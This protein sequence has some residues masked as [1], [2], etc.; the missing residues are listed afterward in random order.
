[1]FILISRCKLYYSE[2]R[3]PLFF[4]KLREYI[5]HL[6]PLTNQTALF[7]L[8]IRTSPL[9]GVKPIPWRYEFLCPFGVA[10]RNRFRTFYLANQTGLL[11]QSIF[12]QCPKRCKSVLWKK[13]KS[14]FS[15]RQPESFSCVILSV[16]VI[17]KQ[18]MSFS[19]L[20]WTTLLCQIAPISRV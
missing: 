15:C 12:M 2:N 6:L 7:S 3:I 11:Y 8:F 14:L 18:N 1:M 10:S 16:I 5:S 19:H 4:R 17:A 9:K 20:S 13:S